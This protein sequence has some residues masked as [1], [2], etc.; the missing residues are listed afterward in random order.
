MAETF[1]DLLDRYGE[2]RI[3]HQAAFDAYQAA[4]NDD[5]NWVGEPVVLDARAADVD[6]AGEVVDA[7]EAAILA[8]RDRLQAEVERLRGAV[9]DIQAEC[10]RCLIV[11]GVPAAETP[12]THGYGK[13]LDIAARSLLASGDAR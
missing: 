12:T 13:I 2:A 4:G 5:A 3:A 9:L 6:K 1:R 11:Q 8:A 7:A 10:N